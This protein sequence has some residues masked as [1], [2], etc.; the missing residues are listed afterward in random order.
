MN[1]AI[2]KISHNQKSIKQ[3]INQD[4]FRDKSDKEKFLEK[5]KIQL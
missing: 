2:E 5:T 1:E 4:D 3:S